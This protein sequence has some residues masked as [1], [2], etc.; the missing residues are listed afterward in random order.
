VFTEFLLARWAGFDQA[1][2]L[3]ERRKH[4]KRAIALRDKLGLPLIAERVR[5][6]ARKP[7]RKLDPIAKELARVERELD[8]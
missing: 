4:L 8:G 2:S 7:S 5:R 3:K 6:R 1:R